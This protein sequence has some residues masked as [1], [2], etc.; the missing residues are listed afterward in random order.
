MI[1]RPFVEFVSNKLPLDCRLK[2]IS[3][4]VLAKFVS[5]LYLRS[6]AQVNVNTE[7]SRVSKFATLV[8]QITSLPSNILA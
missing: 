8:S 2:E 4:S 3:I 6:V 7:P 5:N 1:A